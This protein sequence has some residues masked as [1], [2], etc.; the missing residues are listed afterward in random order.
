MS[1]SVRL[2]VFAVVLLVAFAIAFGV[3]TLFGSGG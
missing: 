1:T 3:G 2:I